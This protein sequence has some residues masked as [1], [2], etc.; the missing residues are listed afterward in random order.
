MLTVLFD[1]D[2]TIVQFLNK[3]LAYHRHLYNSDITIEDIHEWNMPKEFKDIFMTPYFFDGLKPYS[4]AIELINELTIKDEFNVYIVTDTGG[5]VNIVN[6]KY[7]WIKKYLPFINLR[8]NVIFT[9]NKHLIKADILIDDNPYILKKFPNTTIA[10]D[11]PYNKH[12]KTWFRVY[13]NNFKNIKELIYR[14]YEIKRS[15]LK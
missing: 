10:I 15:V 8:E 11:R 6:G 12:I 14:I 9:K 1:M 13:D 5:E 3:L 2:E 4:G 7:F